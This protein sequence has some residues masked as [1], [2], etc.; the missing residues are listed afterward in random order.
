MKS[1]VATEVVQKMNP[2][3]RVRAYVDGVFP[4]TEHIF[5]DHFFE[6]L[7]G[8]VNALDNVKARKYFLRN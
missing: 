6:K 8:V 7:D 5:N 3:M 2:Q 1:T 4:E